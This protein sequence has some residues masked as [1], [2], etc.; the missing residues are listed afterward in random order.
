VRFPK[1]YYMAIPL[2]MTGNPTVIAFRNWLRAEQAQGF[3]TA[4]KLPTTP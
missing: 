2:A 4:K 3:S 1:A